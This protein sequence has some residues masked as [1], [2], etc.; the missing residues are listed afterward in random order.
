M[1]QL[2]CG[3]SPLEPDHFLLGFKMISYCEASLVRTAVVH[4]KTRGRDFFAQKKLLFSAMAS[5]LISKAAD[6]KNIKKNQFTA[7]VLHIRHI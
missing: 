2:I 1:N 5:K 7:A 4:R 3:I 6:S